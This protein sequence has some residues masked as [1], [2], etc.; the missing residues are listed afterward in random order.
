MDS[1]LYLFFVFVF[2]LSFLCVPVV[3]SQRSQANFWFGPL[4]KSISE[5]SDSNT[6]KCAGSSVSGID[7]HK[8]PADTTAKNEKL[9]NQLLNTLHTLECIYNASDIILILPLHL[10]EYSSLS[11]RSWVGKTATKVN[12][13]F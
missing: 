10:I 4:L 8:S 7:K 5:K 13:M 1:F 3:K 2:F 6:G 12:F 9:S 11:G